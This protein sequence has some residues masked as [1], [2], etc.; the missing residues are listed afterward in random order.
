LLSSGI[1]EMS[2]SF[3]EAVTVEG[4]Q[5]ILS[6]QVARFLIKS[7]HAV[8]SGKKVAGSVTYLSDPPVDVNLLDE[9][10]FKGEKR[11]D[12]LLVL[13]K[14]RAS[15]LAY[16]LA[17]GFEKAMKTGKSFDA[18][19]NSVALLAYKA[20]ECHSMFAMA[21]NTDI[22]LREYVQDPATAQVLRRLHELF[23]LQQV[24]GS[25]GDWVGVL[26][27]QHAEFVYDRIVELLDE[28][29]PDA[30]ALVDAFGWDDNQL[31]S[32]IGRF[33]GNVY[34]AIYEMA[35]SSP[36]NQSPKMEGWDDFSTVLDLDF[37]R[38]GMKTQRAR[39]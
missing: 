14:D 1:A 32:A 10:G 37:I 7:A 23:L 19:L 25:L 13:L 35:R 36:L 39:L 38:E 2:R 29:R 20:A 31:G 28:I 21:R 22:A 27:E 26:N 6:L 8:K 5:V 17:N 3:S 34:E 15:R 18:S 9:R 33:D 11:T 12:L 30:V 16:R 24:H 4:E